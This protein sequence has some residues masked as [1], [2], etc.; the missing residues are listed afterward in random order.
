MLY[1][2]A[3]TY[4]FNIHTTSPVFTMNNRLGPIPFKGY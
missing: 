1:P 3:L 4:N 2:F